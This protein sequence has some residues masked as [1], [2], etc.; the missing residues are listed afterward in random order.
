M[1]CL[2]CKCGTSKKICRRCKSFFSSKNDFNRFCE[3]QSSENKELL[4]TLLSLV[5][6][7]TSDFPQICVALSFTELVTKLSQ[8]KDLFDLVQF[9]RSNKDAQKTNQADKK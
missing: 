5:R 1:S 6:S 4:V 3:N 8:H 7:I 9:V 2:V